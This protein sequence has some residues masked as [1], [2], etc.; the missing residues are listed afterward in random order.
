MASRPT[1]RRSRSPVGSVLPVLFRDHAVVDLVEQACSVWEGTPYQHG[2]CSLHYGVDCIHFGAAVLDALYGVRHS[3]NLRSLPPDAC[4]HNRKGVQKALKLML[5]T[6]PGI[7]R[8]DD[9]F[10]EPG[11]LLVLGPVVSGERAEA[12]HLMVVGQRGRLWHATP[13]RVC[14]T[15]YVISDH[16]ELLAVYRSSD[17]EVWHAGSR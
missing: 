9:G 1:T 11:D 8:S 12:A 6:Y 10:I 7:R 5:E 17:K 15:G 3:K 14:F 2:Q 16:E 4:V 13:P